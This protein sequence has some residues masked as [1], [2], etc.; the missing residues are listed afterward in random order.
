MMLTNGPLAG[1]REHPLLAPEAIERV[2]SARVLDVSE[3]TNDAIGR[4]CPGRESRCA[5]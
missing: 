5:A 4:F 1:P 2:K 3:L